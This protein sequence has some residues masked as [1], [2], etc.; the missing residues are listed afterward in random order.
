MSFQS[1]LSSN[2]QLAAQLDEAHGDLEAYQK[3][4]QKEAQE[5]L[6]VSSGTILKNA[7]GYVCALAI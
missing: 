2:A 1:P 5:K 6:E 4:L 7:N 3:M